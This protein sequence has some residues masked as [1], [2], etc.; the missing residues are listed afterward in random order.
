MLKM[1]FIYTHDKMA[2]YN[3]TRLRSKTKRRL[4]LIQELLFADDA[5]LL[6]HPEENPKT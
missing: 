3:I 4:I 6:A 2:N 5:A 1:A